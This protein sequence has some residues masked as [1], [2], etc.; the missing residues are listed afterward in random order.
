MSEERTGFRLWAAAEPDLC[1]IV[2]AD[3]RRISTVTCSPR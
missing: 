1:A 2:T 3:D